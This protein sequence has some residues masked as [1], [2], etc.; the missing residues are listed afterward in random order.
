M[1][2]RTF[3]AIEDHLGEGAHWN[4]RNSRNVEEIA[5]D[6]EDDGGQREDDEVGMSINDDHEDD[7]PT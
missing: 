4:G 2:E 7:H 1:S 5:G 6:S 3:Q